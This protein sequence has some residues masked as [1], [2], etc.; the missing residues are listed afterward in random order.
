MGHENAKKFK[1][2]RIKELL[3]SIHHLPM[4]EQKQRMEDRLAEWMGDMEQIDD[5]LFI[6]R[7]F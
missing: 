7:K 1:A 3:L 5:I 6:G 4:K 2:S